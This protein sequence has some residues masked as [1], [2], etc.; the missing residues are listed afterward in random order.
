MTND[1]STTGYLL[2]VDHSAAFNHIKNNPIENTFNFL[3]LA[4][5]IVHI[6]NTTGKWEI[7]C[8]V[9][10]T[11]KKFASMKNLLQNHEIS[12]DTY[13]FFARLCL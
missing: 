11:K 13:H 6:E 8:R 10:S 3:Y 5:Q 2:F 7:N 1:Q 4:S 12:R 9:K